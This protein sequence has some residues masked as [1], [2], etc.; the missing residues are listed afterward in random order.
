MA[1]MLALATTTYQSRPDM[2]P[3]RRKRYG[4]ADPTVTA[5]TRTPI[6]RPRSKRNQPAMIFMPTG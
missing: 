3:T 2:T 1:A 6:A 5:P 4:S